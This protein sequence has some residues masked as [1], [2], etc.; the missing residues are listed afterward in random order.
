MLSKSSTTTLIC[1][2][3]FGPGGGDGG[4]RSGGWRTDHKRCDLRIPTVTATISIP[5]RCMGKE[6]LEGQ[7]I[8]RRSW[9]RES[10]RPLLPVRSYS[11]NV[12]RQHWSTPSSPGTIGTT[13]SRHAPQIHEAG[14]AFASQ[15]RANEAFQDESNVVTVLLILCFRK[16]QSP[17]HLTTTLNNDGISGG[18]CSGS[19][20]RYGHLCGSSC[21]LPAE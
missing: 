2:L 12:P 18:D 1:T 6:N 11:I 17:H 9:G 13:K 16:Q 19:R 7:T 21:G 5:W 15:A 20:F 14:Q 4:H 8:S 3:V 10:W